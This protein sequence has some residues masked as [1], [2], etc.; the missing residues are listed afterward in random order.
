MW[1]TPPSHFLRHVTRPG[2][3]RG[4]GVSEFAICMINFA[5][6]LDSVGKLCRIFLPG[7]SGNGEKEREREHFS[8]GYVISLSPFSPCKT[9]SRKR[10]RILS[11]WEAKKI[12]LLPKNLGTSLA[13]EKNFRIKFGTWLRKGNTARGFFAFFEKLFLPL[14]WHFL[15]QGTAEELEGLG[16]RKKVT[17]WLKS[18][19]NAMKI[20]D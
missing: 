10:K 12:F 11:Y 7:A 1:S 14:L 19:K 13:E 2:G 8:Q 15:S 3:A 17:P 20:H 4:G 9:V 5:A 16:K 18:R 6:S